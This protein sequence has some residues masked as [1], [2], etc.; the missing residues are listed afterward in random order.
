[1]GRKRNEAAAGLPD[2]D[3]YLEGRKRHY[4]TYLDGARLYDLSYQTFV[5]LAKTAKANLKMRK[6]VIVDV[7]RIEKY[8]ADN[9]EEAIYYDSLRRC[10]HGEYE[11][12]VVAGKSG[13]AD[14]KRR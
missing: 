12:S 14:L 7:D 1:M 9:F 2:L 5:K 6:T 8:L 13:E 3:K 10:E 11:K 4:V